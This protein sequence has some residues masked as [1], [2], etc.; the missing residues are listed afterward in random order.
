MRVLIG[1]AQ[2]VLNIAIIKQL[3]ISLPNKV[4][5]TEIC[6]VINK[7]EKLIDKQNQKLIKTKLQ[8][9]LMEE[10]L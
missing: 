4:E 8:K 10:L 3:L 9:S 5:Q 1:S 2:A 6:G 7:L